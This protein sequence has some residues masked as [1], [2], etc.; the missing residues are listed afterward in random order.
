[1]PC[2]PD[3]R[4]KQ[5]VKIAVFGAS[6][7]HQTIKRATGE[8]TGY[9]EVLR[10]DHAG[11]LGVTEIRQITYSGNRLSDG[12]LIQ[13]DAVI[14]YAPDI[15]LFEPL[16]EDTRRGMLASIAEIRY[17]YRRL[18]LAGVLPVTVLLPI[19]T[20]R[21]VRQSSYAQRFRDLCRTYDLPLIEINLS[22]VG[23]LDEKFNGVHTRQGGAEIYAAQ[24]ADGLSRIQGISETVA[25]AARR[26][27]A[28][29]VPV[30]IR[31]LGVPQ[32]PPE[33][34]K[35]L[36]VHLQLEQGR[37]S[38]V[39][40]VQAMEVGPFS[41]V[42]DVC[43]DRGAGGAREHQKISVWDPYCHFARETFVALCN[44][45]VTGTAPHVLS[46]RC[47]HDDPEYA[48]CTRKVAN[49]PPPKERHLRP[50]GP[51]YVITD[52]PF[53]AEIKTYHPA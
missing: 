49:W 15:C 5:P 19:P 29:P 38:R 18:L 2:A 13:L 11:A 17:V 37:S 14:D 32:G 41:P 52:Q 35:G 39:R 23:D 1:M 4:K 40:L 9:A 53:S 22:R 50:R 47:M 7:S 51:L 44:L 20:Q 16:I 48:M 28:V 8:V 3:D 27:E 26:I 25:Q 30:H 12:G 34:S 33:Q 10:R 6:V 42:I 46:I 43:L 45:N 21:K 24:I 36:D 31:R